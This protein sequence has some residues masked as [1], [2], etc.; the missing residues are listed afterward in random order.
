[1]LKKIIGYLL[2]VLAALIVIGTLITIPNTLE[3]KTTAAIAGRLVGMVILFFVAFLLFRVGR[4]WQGWRN[5][6]LNT[7]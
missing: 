1:M 7:N 3:A 5:R 6:K 2:L 4:R